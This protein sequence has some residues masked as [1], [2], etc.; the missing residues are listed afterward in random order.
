MLNYGAVAQASWDAGS[1]QVACGVVSPSEAGLAATL[2]ECQGQSPGDRSVVAPP[3]GPAPPVDRRPGPVDRR[4]APTTGASLHGIAGSRR[5]ATG[6]PVQP[7]TVGD[8]AR[9]VACAGT[10]PRACRRADRKRRTSA[11]SDRG[12]RAAADHVARVR[13]AA[14]TAPTATAAA[15]GR[16]TF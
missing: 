8:V 16:V 6:P 15:T 4:P 3:Q 12:S 2:R 11:G 7:R 14:A 9:P 13:T 5:H 10:S 1:R